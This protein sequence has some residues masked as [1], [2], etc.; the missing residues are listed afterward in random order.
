M[1]SNNSMYS[2]NF[3]TCKLHYISKH[4]YRLIIA[5]YLSHSGVHFSLKDQCWA[6]AVES[7]LR[8]L[9]HAFCVHD[10]HDEKELEKILKSV[11]FTG[12]V[13]VIITCP[14]QNKVYDVARYVSMAVI[15]SLEIYLHIHN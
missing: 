9:M 11:C 7:C 3:K 15:D 12:R 4:I 5:C 1:Y 8:S 6:L 13:P 14:F 2:R 10:H